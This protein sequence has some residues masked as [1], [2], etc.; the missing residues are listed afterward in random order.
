[1]ARLI[2][3]WLVDV[4]GWAYDNRARRIARALPDYRHERYFNIVKAIGMGADPVAILNQADVI[5]CPDP[6]LLVLLPE[7]MKRKIVQSLN[8]VKIF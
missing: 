7:K 1:M 4:P 8:A 3:A 6:R 5:V 2:I